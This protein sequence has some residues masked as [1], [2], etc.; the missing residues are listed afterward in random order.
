MISKRIGYLLFWGLGIPALLLGQN[1]DQ[2]QRLR[3]S[4]EVPTDFLLS[5]TSK[6]QLE[7][8]RLSDSTKGKRE[9]LEGFF[10]EDYYYI[11]ELL[12]SGKV[13]FND[14][15]SR[16]VRRVADQLLVEQKEIRQRLRFY[17]V[18]SSVANAFA[19]TDG[20]ILVNLGL[21]AKLENEA[22]LAFILAHEISHYLAQHPVEIFLNLHARENDQNRLFRRAQGSDLLLAR[23]FYSK[24]KEQEADIMG[25]DLYLK[26]RYD[27]ESVNTVFRVL[28]LADAPFGD[29]EFLRSYLE[30]SSIQFNERNWLDTLLNPGPD[31]LPNEVQKSLSTH[32]EPDARRDTMMGRIAALPNEGRV[33]WQV[34]ESD[35]IA[36]RKISRYEL[37]HLYLV[38][39]AYESAIYCAY[40]LQQQYGQSQ[41][42]ERTIAYALYGLAKY[43]NAGRFWDV[44][45]DYNEVPGPSQQLH[46]LVEKLTDPER[47]VLALSHAW[48]R[49]QQ[50]PDDLE[51][52]LIVE[53]L[54]TEI[55]VYYVDSLGFFLRVPAPAPTMEVRTAS[56]SRYGLSEWLSDPVFTALLREKLFVGR[57]KRNVQE[58]E[59]FP[60]KSK[61][62]IQQ[63][64]R[65]KGFNLGLDRIVLVTPMYQRLDKRKAVEVQFLAS[66]AVE[67]TYTSQ[68]ETHAMNLNLSCTTMA[69]SRLDEFQVVRFN[70][71]MLLSEWV[72]E[73]NLHTDFPMVSILH[74][75][76]QYLAEKYETPYFVWTQGVAVTRPRP[77][78]KMMLLMGVIVPLLPYS[79][80]YA[81]TPDHNLFFYT[82]V[83]DIT[84][85][86]YLIVYPQRL[87]LKDRND[88]INSVA[89]DLIL[90]LKTP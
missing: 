66:E 76:V 55:G 38:E 87:N 77:G 75:E 34:G 59:T 68:L 48:R 9:A 30:S 83:Y 52:K 5:A 74:Q 6:Y 81:L 72:A 51:L 17:V 49:Y 64:L 47:N 40:F 79:L 41:Y 84:R 45:L 88:V 37:C 85:G 63:E 7:M 70:E 2:Y 36:A 14:P 62:Q 24:E 11:N 32:P 44:H 69:F 27:L 33:V 86:D 65:I 19:T 54:M 23:N 10:Q 56:F 28:K 22:Q 39:Q 58:T 16:Y 26:A 21:I 53:D 20:I 4:G 61:E 35:F 8:Q 42:L 82:A 31:Q 71:L 43:T 3:C 67:N 89:Y 90:Q 25:L 46:Y 73:R 60:E 1:F 50:Y 13:L 80:Y 78:R 57:Q 12:Q 18:K 15:V 29:F